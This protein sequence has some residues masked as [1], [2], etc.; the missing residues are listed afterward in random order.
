MAHSFVI[1]SRMAALN[2]DSYNRNA[3]A[4]FDLDNGNIV[5]LDTQGGITE[6]Y[7]EVWNATIPVTN[8]LVG[9][10]MVRSPE[11]MFV[12]SMIESDPREFY[13]KAGKVFDATYLHPGDIFTITAEGLGGAKG[14]FTDVIAVDGSAKLTWGAPVATAFYAKLIA[15]TTIPGAAGNIPAYKFEVKYNPI[16]AFAASAAVMSVTPLAN[17]VPV[18]DGDGLLNSGWLAPDATK[19]DLL[20]SGTNIKTINSTSLLGSG[21][22]VIPTPP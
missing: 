5:R 7:N 12:N 2:I 19:Q 9:L 16:V 21:D 18:A 1:Q 11:A 22:I 20:V 10:W 6:S 15:T 17:A 14:S 4:R 13:V 8:S 3:V